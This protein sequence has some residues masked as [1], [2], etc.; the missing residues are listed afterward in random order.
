MAKL[1]SISASNIV[2]LFCS[3]SYFRDV[4]TLDLILLGKENLEMVNDYKQLSFGKLFFCW[5]IARAQGFSKF[6]L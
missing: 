4:Q 6:Y 2:P 1:F 3:C 5:K